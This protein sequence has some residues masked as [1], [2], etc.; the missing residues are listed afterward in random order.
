MSPP[1]SLASYLIDRLTVVLAPGQLLLKDVAH[2]DET[3]RRERQQLRSAYSSDAG[4][5]ARESVA[6]TGALA[7]E[8]RAAEAEL[9]VSD[10]AIA[11]LE[12]AV[13]EAKHEASQSALEAAEAQARMARVETTVREVEVQRDRI[14]EE[15]CGC[16]QPSLTTPSAPLGTPP[17]CV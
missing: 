9:A 6:T 10:S 16:H 14:D 17:L 7:V 8:L 3:F 11:A 1:L 5:L 2:S 4:E 15:R 13:E 12:D